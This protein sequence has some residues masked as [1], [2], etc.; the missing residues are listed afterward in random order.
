MRDT[1]LNRNTERNH[2]FEFFKYVGPDDKINLTNVYK[3]VS[4]LLVDEWLQW[5]ETK[6]KADLNRQIVFQEDTFIVI[7]SSEDDKKDFY[8]SKLQSRIL[9]LEGLSETIVNTKKAIRELEEILLKAHKAFDDRILE[10]NN[11]KEKI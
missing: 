2:L 10:I 1:P 5:L 6:L 8:Q 7:F 11:L 3:E 4:P 9:D